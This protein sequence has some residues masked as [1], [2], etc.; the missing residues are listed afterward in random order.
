MRLSLFLPVMFSVGA[1]PLFGQG[2][3]CTLN[4]GTPPFVRSSGFSEL[5]GD[6]VANC[7]GGTPTPNGGMIPQYDI[8]ITLNG[9]VSSRLLTAGGMLEALLI[10]DE[11]NS[12]A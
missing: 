8:S 11:P 9:P 7:Q 10:V 6:I 12:T 4:A 3:V 2:V 5:L 1:V